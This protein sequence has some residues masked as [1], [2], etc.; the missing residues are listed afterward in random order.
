M[1]AQAHGAT[2]CPLLRKYDMKAVVFLIPGYVR[3]ATS[4]APTLKDVWAGRSRPETLASRDPR[5]MNWSEVEA[6]AATGA[7]DFQSHTLYHHRVPI[8]D[9]IVDYVNPKASDALFDLPIALGQEEQLC[10]DGVEG[11]L[12]APIYENDSLMAGRPVYRPDPRLAEA[13]MDYVRSMGGR[14]FF[15]SPGWRKELHQRARAWREGHDDRGRFDDDE[16]VAHELRKGLRRARLLI[17]QRLPGTEVR[18]LCYPYTIGSDAAI[19]ASR[20]AGYL[21]NFWGVLPDRRSNRRG[22][23]P[24]RCARL[25]GDYLQRLP[26]R[27]RITLVGTIARKVSRRVLARP[28]Y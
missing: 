3:E 9:R 12:G 10:A 22:D 27:G 24:Y 1:V 25:K 4:L 7:I 13:C 18:H 14:A 5:L 26:G 11:M 6:A 21:T 20:E 2:A 28:I 16:A 8:S 15:G 23:D 19:R 17:E